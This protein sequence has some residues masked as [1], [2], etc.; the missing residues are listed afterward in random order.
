[1][2]ATAGYTNG[3]CPEGA[4]TQLPP[5]GTMPAA[6]S[7]QAG[8]GQLVFYDANGRLALNDGTVPGLVSG[9]VAH[10]EKLSP[11]STTAGAAQIMT[12]WG[13]GGHSPGSTTANDTPLVSSICTPVW[14]SNENTVGLLSN[15]GGSNRSLAGLCLGLYDDGTPRVWSGPVASAVAR[16]VLIADNFALAAHGIAD[17]AASTAVAERPVSHRPRV[18]G[19]VTSVWFQGLVEAIGDTDFAVITIS[20][21]DGAG[22]G[23]VSMATYDTRAAGNGA[24]VA[25]VPKQF[26]LSVVAGALNLLETDVVTITTTKGGSGQIITGSI[27]VNGKAL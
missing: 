20:K 24:V 17:A 19:T 18:K 7:S 6:A 26:T 9:G 5:S 23:A 1:M 11:L 13:F 3:W 14:C 10:P 15:S 8:L 4:G 21:R 22:G 12:W 27:L 25:F 2:T 16:A